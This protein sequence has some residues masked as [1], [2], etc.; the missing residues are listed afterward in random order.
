MRI[1][2]ALAEELGLSE[3][4]THR[5][6]SS[7]RAEERRAWTCPDFRLGP[8]RAEALELTEMTA[9]GEEGSSDPVVGV[10]GTSL[11]R[12]LVVEL[13]FDGPAVRFYDPALYDNPDIAWLPFR[14]AHSLPV[15]SCR[16]EGGGEGDFG[17][18][19]RSPLGVVFFKPE[20]DARGLLADKVTRPGTISG[21]NF[22]KARV[23]TGVLEWFETA[24]FRREKA[25]AVFLIEDVPL[26]AAG[27]LAGLIGRSALGGG[28][29]LDY[30]RS[31]L[32][33]T[34]RGTS[35]PGDHHEALRGGL[36]VGSALGNRGGAGPGGRASARSSRDRPWGHR[37]RS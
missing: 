3:S 19:L 37:H 9:G 11:L 10:V 15:V 18:D 6:V 32:A 2:A 22:G 23:R 33:V 35:T 20:V 34:A 12:G 24:G 1:T 29:T 21:P 14:V 13:E 8:C 28:L 16:Y 25:P 17:L 4:G 26:A 36:L 7:S 27:E 30:A 31:R 5:V